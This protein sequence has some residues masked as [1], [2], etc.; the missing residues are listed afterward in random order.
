VW[1]I[2]LRRGVSKS[3]GCWR[4][5]INAKLR[6]TH[7]DANARSGVRDPVYRTW[8]AMVGRCENPRDSGY[9]NYGGR[10]VEICARWR[11][12]YEAFRDDMGPRPEGAP[13]EW[14]IDRRSTDGHYSCGKCDQCIA[15][16][17]PANCRWATATEQMRNVRYNRM[18]TLRGETMCL[19]AWAERLGIS[20]GTIGDRLRSGWSDER[21]LTTPVDQRK[22]RR[23]AT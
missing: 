22:G 6:T 9:S 10:G 5:E 14:S 1:L 13:R 7:G 19:A 17:W 12:S 4:R 20:H 21:A 23:A 15:N 2:N 16:A 18:L 8:D 11:G 3:C